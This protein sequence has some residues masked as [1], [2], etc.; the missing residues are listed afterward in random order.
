MALDKYGKLT[1]THKR[2]LTVLS[3]G[4]MHTRAEMHECI[5]DPRSD[6]FDMLHDYISE[7]RGILK[8]H[9]EDVACRIR[10]RGIYYQ[11]IRLLVDPNDGRK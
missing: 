5:K 10:G 3:D 6:R 4:L 1:P 9:G 2:I 7:I 8:R 11:H